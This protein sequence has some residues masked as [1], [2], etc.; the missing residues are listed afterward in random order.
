[1]EHTLSL[2]TRLITGS[3]AIIVNILVVGLVIFKDFDWHII[4][5]SIGL[6]GF[7]LLLITLLA[8]KK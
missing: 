7:T 5:R 8:R 3:I 6:T 1:M 2:R 4:S